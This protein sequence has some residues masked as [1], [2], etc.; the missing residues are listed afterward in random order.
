V[1][2]IPAFGGAGGDP[3]RQEFK[4]AILQEPAEKQKNSILPSWSFEFRS[5]VV[6]IAASLYIIAA[7]T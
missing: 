4:T 7:F 2:H 5:A 1:S 6:D 3:G